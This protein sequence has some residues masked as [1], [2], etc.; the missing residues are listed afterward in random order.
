MSTSIHTVALFCG[1]RF[2][3]H[4][5]FKKTAETL[6]AALGKAHIKIV[7][8]GGQRGLMGVVANAA[9]K[10]KGEVYGVI[11]QFLKDREDINESAT[12]LTIT[13]TMH[14]RKYAM[15]SRADAFIIL[16]GGLGTYDEAI[17]V[18]T[19]RQIGL[20]NKP[21][22]FIDTL[23]WT[24]PFCM[25]IK[26]SVEQ[27]FAERSV[28]SYFTIVPDSLTALRKLNIKERTPLSL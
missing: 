27:E 6:G 21:I 14:E 2:G 10:E 18:L 11:P 3:L 28:F 12:A 1:S 4:P 19:W 7:Y 15:Y 25:M 17:E 9:M 20:H 8:G 26:Q 13:A 5:E 23:G 24:K 22:I 16:P